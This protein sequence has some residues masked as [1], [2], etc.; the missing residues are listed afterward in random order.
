M[1]PGNVIGTYV[2]SQCTSIR[3]HV[4]FLMLTVFLTNFIGRL[5]FM[6]ITLCSVMQIL[7]MP[8][9]GYSSNTLYL[10][11]ILCRC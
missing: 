9:L 8:K 11:H 2:L 1:L 10:N 4:I 7:I 5:L 6:L 3:L